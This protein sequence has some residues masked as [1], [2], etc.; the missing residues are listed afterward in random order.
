MQISFMIP[1]LFVTAPGTAAGKT[2]VTR[3]LTRALVLAGRH[4]L[5]LKPVETGISDHAADATA[6]ARVC[7][8]PELANIPGFYRAALS[9]CPYA[10]T[11]ETGVCSPSSQA[12]AACIRALALATTPDPLLVEG[13]GGLLVPLSPTETMAD[14]ATSLDLPLLVVAPDRLGVLS[15]VLTCLE[16]ASRR[17]L[18]VAGVVLTDHGD[19]PATDISSRTNHRILQQ[20]LDVP[21]LAFPHCPDDDDALADAARR[22]GLLS[23]LH[24]P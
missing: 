6:L 19:D 12:L 24:P 4:P 11:L 22:C 18:R 17:Q 8:H 23:L 2:F 13:A 9:L 5:A 20:R 15:S 10:V 1:S 14:L 21:V 3:A 7:G 16:S